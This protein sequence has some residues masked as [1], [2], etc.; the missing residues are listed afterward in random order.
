MA[1]SQ[2]DVG[3]P[4]IE[5]GSTIRPNGLTREMSQRIGIELPLRIRALIDQALNIGLAK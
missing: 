4:S 5:I 3:S 1:L 2:S